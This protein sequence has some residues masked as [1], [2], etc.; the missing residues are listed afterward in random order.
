M[1]DSN[2]PRLLNLLFDKFYLRDSKLPDNSIGLLASCKRL[3]PLPQYSNAGIFVH[4]DHSAEQIYCFF[5][6]HV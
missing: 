2:L 1:L 3:N 6:F 4:L 5:K